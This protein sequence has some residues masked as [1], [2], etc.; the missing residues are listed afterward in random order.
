M[1]SQ[2]I[3]PKPVTEYDLRLLKVFVSVVENQGFSSAANALGITRSTVSV[4]MSNLET[5]M[6]LTLCNRGRSGFSLTSEGQTVYHA[7]VELFTS[8][9]N[10]SM[11]VATVGKDLSGELVILCADQLDTIKQQKLGKVIAEIHEQSPN[12]HFVLDSDSIST[13]EKQLLDGKAHVGLYPSYQSIDGLDASVIFSE[14]IYLCCSSRHKFFDMTDTQI[15][16]KELS[17]ALAIH[18]GIDIDKAGKEQLRKLNLFAKSYQFDTRKA[19]IHSGKFIGFLPQS[20]IQQELN[21]GEIRIIKP[22]TCK[23]DFNLSMVTQKAPTEVNKVKLAK[24][25]FTKVFDQAN[26]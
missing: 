13:I 17:R 5:R 3:I 19:M 18:P 8:F 15:D 16:E 14:S 24:A 1:Y 20:Y 12:L 2:S 7:A 23:Y 11:T 26:L 4:H 10:F 25:A 22:S 9:D 6:G 21:Q